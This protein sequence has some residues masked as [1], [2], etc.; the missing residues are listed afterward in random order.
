MANE[1][2][3]DHLDLAIQKYKDLNSLS[4]WVYHLENNCKVDVA[5]ISV[6]YGIDMNAVKR[7]KR[8][9]TSLSEDLEEWAIEAKSSYG[10]SAP[11]TIDAKPSKNE[12]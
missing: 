10:N 5:Q 12:E 6:K 9:I 1:F 8:V 3:Y 7:A 4:R 11:V 2:K